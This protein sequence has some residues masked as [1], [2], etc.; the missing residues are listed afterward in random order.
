MDLIVG[1]IGRRPMQYP[2]PE[3]NPDQVYGLM[4][5]EFLPAILPGL[6]GI[7]LFFLLFQRLYLLLQFWKY[8][9]LNHLLPNFFLFLHSFSHALSP[10]FLKWVSLHPHH[11]RMKDLVFY[12]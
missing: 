4:A 10:C 3:V 11:Q 5:R 6:L 1:C 9:Y 2:A 12:I 8:I 7:F